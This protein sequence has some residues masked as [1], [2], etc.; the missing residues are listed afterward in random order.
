VHLL[1]SIGWLSH[2]FIYSIHIKKVCFRHDYIFKYVWVYIWIW[3]YYTPCTCEEDVCPIFI[4]LSRLKTP[5]SRLVI[6]SIFQKAIDCL[7]KTDSCGCLVEGFIKTSFLI[8]QYWA[9]IRVQANT[10]N[11][12][13]RKNNRHV[14]LSKCRW[15]WCNHWGQTQGLVEGIIYIYNHF[16]S[17]SNF[18]L[19]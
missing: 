2:S 3:T 7:W 11:R 12:G 18:I 13:V 9:Y 10:V 5:E 1:A 19:Y 16:F 14:Q 8:L 4:Y 17:C 15:W 6:I